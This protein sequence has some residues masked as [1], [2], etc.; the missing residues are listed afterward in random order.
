MAKIMTIDEYNFSHQLKCTNK[1]LLLTTKLQ[2]FL[3][4]GELQSEQ[5][6]F[7]NVNINCSL[8]SHAGAILPNRTALIEEWLTPF[9]FMAEGS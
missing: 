4:T 5:I 9:L 3:Y 2:R 6:F 7:T 8:Q 1:Y